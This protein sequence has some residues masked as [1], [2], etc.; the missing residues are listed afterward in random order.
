M[1]KSI[2]LAMMLVLITGTNFI[3]GQACAVHKSYPIWVSCQ[4]DAT[5][6][7]A[8]TPYTY[9]ATADP[10]GGQ[11][12]WW[13]TDDPAFING[14]VNNSA[15]R[16]TVA[17]GE[18]L[19]T[20]ANYGIPDPAG[21][22]SITWANSTL[23]LPG[24]LFVAVDYAAP[25]SGCANNL[26]VYEITPINAF[27]VDIKNMFG[28]FD[29]TAYG[30]LVDTC[31]SPVQSATYNAAIPAIDYNYGDNQMLFEVV[32]A[33]FSESATV[34]FNIS[35]L[36]PG[37][38]V[39]QLADLSWGCTPATANANSLG[40]GLNNGVVTSTA[41]VTTTEVNTHIG[42]SF[43]VLMTIHNNS[44]EGTANTDISL[45]VNAENAE[46]Q[47]D[48]NNAT[49]LVPTP[50]FEDVATQRLLE[51]P[52]VTNTTPPPAVFLPNN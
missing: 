43:Y 46:G 12:Q 16:F 26:K 4:G 8:G 47:E 5:H 3:F 45:A 49:C 29:T 13:A 34:S 36:M 48:V 28:D 25:L 23:N 42:V 51:R 31:V 37:P 10:S 27:T 39:D 24:P 50:N 52:D 21:N 15:G 38:N 20:S 33:N 22:V 2:L 41:L 9:S 44:Y 40:T 1:K 18:L 11:F 30:Q 6:P 35:G 14:G 19:N 17:A 7:I 32:L